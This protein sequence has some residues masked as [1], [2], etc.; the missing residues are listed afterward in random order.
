MAVEL[1]FCWF[2]WPETVERPEIH[3]PGNEEGVHHFANFGQKNVRS[4][5]EDIVFEFLSKCIQTYNYTLY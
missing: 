1:Q 2:A 3:W 5:S 4:Y